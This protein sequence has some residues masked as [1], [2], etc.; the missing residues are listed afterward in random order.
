M[1]EELTLKASGLSCMG[2]VRTLQSKLSEIPEI[3]SA[4]VTLDPPTAEI[5]L[6]QPIDHHKINSYLESRGI[7]YRVYSDEIIEVERHTSHST[8]ANIP[9]GM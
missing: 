9:D 6:I 3:E 1:S 7:H 8:I 2:C 5:R 4:E